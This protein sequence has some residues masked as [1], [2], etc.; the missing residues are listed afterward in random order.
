[1]SFHY[2]YILQ[3]TVK[4]ETF[5]V[6]ATQDIRSRLHKHNKGDVSH[7]KKHRPW[8]IKNAV[9]FDEKSKALSF[10]KYLKTHSGRA[11]SKKHF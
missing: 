1:M 2:V 11:W 9:A 4:E 7:T 5:Y 3:S 10:E 8:I 6:G